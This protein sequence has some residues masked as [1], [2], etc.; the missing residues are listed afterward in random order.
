MLNGYIF[1]FV[2][3][4]TYIKFVVYKY[5]AVTVVKFGSNL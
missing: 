4:G 1:M 5:S 3:L 2:A